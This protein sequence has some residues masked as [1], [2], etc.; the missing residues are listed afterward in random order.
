MRKDLK[1]VDWDRL[2][3]GKDVIGKWEAF[4]GEILRVQS[5]YVPVRVKGKRNKN[6]NK[7]PWFSRDIGTL[8]KKKREM[9]NMYRQQ[10]K[11]RCLRSIKGVRKYLRKKS[12]GLKEDMSLHW[13]ST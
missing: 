2:F 13:Q 9:Y 7:E 6:K 12:G 4:K 8:I 5:L 10:E 11:I 1:S 3:S